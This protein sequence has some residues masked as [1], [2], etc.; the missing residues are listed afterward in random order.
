M[1]SCEFREI[2]KTSFLTEHLRWL[3]LEIVEGRR[4]L[5]KMA[6]IEKMQNST[7]KLLGQNNVHKCYSRVFIAYSEQIFV[8]W[9]HSKQRDGYETEI[10]K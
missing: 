5:Q 6:Y 8:H 1:F 7:E 3:L 4:S 10:V 9:D 2:C